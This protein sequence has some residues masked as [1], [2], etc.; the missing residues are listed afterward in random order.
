MPESPHRLTLLRQRI[1]QLTHRKSGGTGASVIFGHDS[2]DAALGGGLARGKLHEVVSTDVGD[3]SC[4]AGFAAMLAQRLGGVLVWLRVGTTGSVLSAPGL[5]EIG[6]DPGTILIVS[7]PDPPALIRAAGDV[8]RCGAVGVAVIEVWR[9]PKRIDLTVSRQLVLAAEA[10]GTTAL[11]LR[12]AAEPTPNAAQTRWSVAAAPSVPLAA[13]A[14]G[15]P[16]FELELLRQR[17]GPSGLRWRVEWDREQAIFRDPALPGAV[18][19][20]SA[21]RSLDGGIDADWR[22]TA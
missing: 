11:L 2:I 12:I 4:A 1:D 14:P 17:G 3:A 10:S 5:K 9:D 18:A 6:V 7:A 16:A 20:L 15:F 19:P 13:N 22:R 21:R 8:V